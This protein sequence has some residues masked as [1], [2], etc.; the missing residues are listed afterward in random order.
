MKTEQELRNEKDL[1]NRLRRKNS[2]L[3]EELSKF[4]NL[5]SEPVK[6]SK[7]K[8]GAKLLDKLSLNYFEDDN[9]IEK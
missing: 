5:D 8:H 3:T 1:N 2:E 4:P 6:R 7:I 9:K